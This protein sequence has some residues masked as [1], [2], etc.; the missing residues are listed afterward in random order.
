MT[1]PIITITQE[2]KDHASKCVDYL[3]KAFAF[4]NYCRQS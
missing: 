1:F 4:S 3:R 2:D